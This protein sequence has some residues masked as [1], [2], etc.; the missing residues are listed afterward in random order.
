MSKIIFNYKGTEIEIQCNI[1]DKI[2][3]IFKK[4]ADKSGI[5]ISKTYFLY[6]GNKINDNQNLNEKMSEVDKKRKIMKILV[7]D[8][9]TIIKE[10][11]IEIKEIVC[12]KCNENILIKINEYKIS[13][14]KCKNNHEINNILLN[15]IENVEK[16]D[17]SKI[18]CGV[19]MKIMSKTFNNEFYRCNFCKI[20][21]CP[22]CKSKH[23]N[24]NNINN[25]NNN[26]HNIINYND[27]NYI[28]EMHNMN[29][30]KYCEYC[31]L[32][33]CMLCFEEHKNKN[34]SI[35]NFEDIISNEEYIIK[36][37]KKLE[38]YINNLNNNINDKIKKLN[39]VKDNLNIYYN[40]YKNTID[41]YILR[42]INYNLINNIKEFNNYNNNIIIK[43]INEIINDNNINNQFNKIINIYDKMSIKINLNNTNDY[44]NKI[45]H[46]FEKD[47]NNLKYKYDIS[48]T[49]AGC[50]G[51]N[52]IFEVFKSYK[53]NKEY[54]I[55]KNINYNLDIFQLLDNQKIKSLN[56]H[57]NHIM[58]VRYFINNK[59]YN[60]YLISSDANHIVI[61]WDITNNFDIKYKI[62]NKYN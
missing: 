59:Y 20:N 4:Y 26:N 43:D 38:E 53:D 34:H 12:P 54:I 16:I 8:N 47:P 35:I 44:N 62:Y 37:K 31:K 32:D 23:N 3:D 51:I 13:L 15:E 48:N 55:S 22:L 6:N 28:C 27:K 56:G 19:C 60:E 49:N 52:D 9:E 25:N 29:F 11:K 17:L 40:L 7:N 5:D 57:K 10:K 58:T 21:L 39:K 36:E 41:K 18:I 61:I 30:I 1:Q 46:K 50:N 24:K 45:I 14:V 42:K 33:I 2:K